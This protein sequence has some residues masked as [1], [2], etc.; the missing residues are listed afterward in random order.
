M[1]ERADAMNRQ[2]AI[3]QLFDLDAVLDGTQDF[4]WRGMGDAWYSGVLSGNLLHIRQSVSGV[5]YRAHSDL[6]ALLRSY[7]RLDDDLNAI[8]ADISSRDDN[9][10]RLVSKYPRLRLLRQP[11]PWECTVAYI[12]STTNSIGRIR[13]LVERIAKAL[14]RPLELDGEVRHAFPTPSTVLEAGVEALEQLS[15]GLKRHDKIVSAAERIRD[16]KLDLHYLA[17]PQVCY[18]EAKRRLMGCYGI[19]DKVADCIALFALDKMDAF[20]VDRWVERAMA[21]YFP[22]R[23]P[24]TGDELVMWAQDYFGEYAGYANQLLFHG[25]WELAVVE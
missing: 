5:E 7:F 20:P 10:A 8:Y 1:P 23:Q 18:A 11:D 2:L 6:N 9:V 4:R 25:Q 22:C 17:Q 16:G 21:G 19:G 13:T 15:L 24:P 3:D 12:C 14:G